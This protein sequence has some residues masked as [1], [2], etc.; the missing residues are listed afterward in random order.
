MGAMGKGRDNVAKREYRQSLVSEKDFS[1]RKLSAMLS[2][3][4]D[5]LSQDVRKDSNSVPVSYL[6]TGLC[7]PLQIHISLS[8][9]TEQGVPEQMVMWSIA[10]QNN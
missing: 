1:I 5:T 8:H 10:M 6:S 7:G 3:D 4:K 9:D 2:S